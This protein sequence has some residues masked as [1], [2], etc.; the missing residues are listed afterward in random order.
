M[1]RLHGL[2]PQGDQRRPGLVQRDGV[3]LMVR[4]ARSFPQAD[5]GA[6]SGAGS[7]LGNGA[8]GHRDPDDVVSAVVLAHDAVENLDVDGGGRGRAAPVRR[9]RWRTHFGMVFTSR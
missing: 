6:G 8:G 2:E 9:H 1:I 5:D 4:R 3:H 7:D